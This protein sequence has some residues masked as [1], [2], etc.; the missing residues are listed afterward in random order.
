M[1]LLNWIDQLKQKTYLQ[2][3]TIYLRYLIGGTF[4]IAAI[5]MGKLSGGVDLVN[6][7]SAPIQDLMPLQQ[8][9]RVMMDSGLYWQFIGWSQII[10]GILLATQRFSK[11]GA[12]IF[13]GII[14][15]IFVITISYDFR[16]TP[17]VT[18]LLLLATSYLLVW[19]IRSFLVLITDK[20]TPVTLNLKVIDHKFWAWLGGIMV[21]GILVVMM[22]K[23]SMV[24]QLGTPFM[25][26]L[27]GF[28]VYFTRLNRA[29]ISL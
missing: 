16:G 19:D 28:I 6:A 13:F 4:I 12:L 17:I 24:F 14:L 8:F 27:I 25:I 21:V 3:F 7:H 1:K 23:L 5:G 11:L 22:L 9:F 18:G 20:F 10:A 26:G 2:I 15:N 29:S